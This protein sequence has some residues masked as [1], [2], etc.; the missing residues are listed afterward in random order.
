MVA[1]SDVPLPSTTLGTSEED[2]ALRAMFARMNAAAPHQ[3]SGASMTTSTSIGR[4]ASS[5]PDDAASV[6]SDET[7]EWHE[8]HSNLDDHEAPWPD[9][10]VAAGEE[11]EKSPGDYEVRSFAF[12]RVP[13]CF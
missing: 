13:A 6:A 8:T 3:P 5:S 4:D 9:G 2:E 11:Q 12:V 10:E 7:E 1:S